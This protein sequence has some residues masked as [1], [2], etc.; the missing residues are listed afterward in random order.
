M[1]RSRHTLPRPTF[2]LPHPF[3]F[4][5]PALSVVEGSTVDSLLSPF[6]A[7]LARVIIYLTNQGVLAM[8]WGVEGRHE[9]KNTP[10]SDSVL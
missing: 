1:F 9:A 4:Q 2:T 3:D 10:A 6:P 5:L 7:T 8:L